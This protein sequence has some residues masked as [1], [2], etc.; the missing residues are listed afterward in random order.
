M[1]EIIDYG[2]R[3]GGQA[4]NSFVHLH[5]RHPFRLVV[6]GKKNSFS[7]NHMR[8]CLI[9]IA[10]EIDIPCVTCRPTSERP[11]V[12]GAAEIFPKNLAMTE[13]EGPLETLPGS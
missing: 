9:K 4:R 5:M 13:S 1:D 3:I 2:F 6:T 7:G 11:L 12:P 10:R 8:K